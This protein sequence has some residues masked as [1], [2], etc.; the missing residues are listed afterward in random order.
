MGS[1]STIMDPVPPDPNPDAWVGKSFLERLAS[2]EER[3]R[4]LE[5]RLARQEPSAV[6][7]LDGTPGGLPTQAE[8]ACHRLRNG[9]AV[10]V[11]VNRNG[12][13]C[14]EIVIGDGD[15]SASGGVPGSV[16]SEIVLAYCRDNPLCGTAT[17]NGDTYSWAGSSGPSAL[18]AR[19]PAADS[20]G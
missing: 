15:W 20:P 2:L 13:P 12:Q 11:P 8:V 4:Y 9:K 7:P 17:V 18:E 5:G 16:Q 3:V 1:V 6:P 10:V 19:T 14:G